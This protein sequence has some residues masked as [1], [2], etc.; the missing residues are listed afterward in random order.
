MERDNEWK[1]DDN[2]DR[3][4]DRLRE[5]LG[6]NKF[7]LSITPEMNMC[8]VAEA[9][10]AVRESCTDNSMDTIWD[11]S[12]DFDGLKIQNIICMGLG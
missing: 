1:L 10:R 7:D 11:D 6:E 4:A 12:L 5:I 9:L 2:S 3:D 8:G